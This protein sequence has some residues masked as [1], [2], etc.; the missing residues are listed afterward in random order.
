MECQLNNLNPI[1]FPNEVNVDTELFLPVSSHATSIECMSGYFTSGVL[2]ELAQSFKSFLSSNIG[3]IKFI[4]SPNLSPADVK[5][6]IEAEESRDDVLDKLFPNYH[7]EIESLKCKT[8]EVFFYLILTKRIE[9]KIAV[10]NEGVFHTKA[11]IFNTSEG[12]VTIHGSG[13]ATSNGLST[14]FE[15]LTLSRSW[16]NDDSRQVCG[17]LKNRFDKIWANNYIGIHTYPLN[18]KTLESVKRYIELKKTFNTNEDLIKDLQKKYNEYI[19]QVRLE[20]IQTRA[21]KIPSYLQYTEGVYAHQGK[22]VD[23]WFKNIFKGILAIATGGG[24]TL[25][26]LVAASKLNEIHKNLFVVIAVPT[27][28]LLNQWAEDVT[29]FGVIPIISSNHKKRELTSKINDAIR[30]IK[31]GISTCE[32]LIITHDA[33]KSDLMTLFDEAQDGVHFMLIGDEVHNLGSTGFIERAPNFFTFKLGLSA[34]YERQ[35]DADGT[36]FLIEYFGDVIFEYGLRDAIGYCLVPYDYYLHK[37]YLTAEEEDNFKEV[38]EKIRKLSYAA[39]FPDGSQEKSSWSN[40]CLKRRRII[41]TAENKISVFKDVFTEINNTKK[42]EKTLIFCTDK[43]NTQISEINNYLN[44]IS[45][46]WHQITSRETS[47]SARL[48]SIVSEFKNNELQVL[49]AMRVL[50]EGFNIPQTE[51]AYLLSSNTVRRQWI[52]RL[53]RILRLSPETGKRKAALHDFLVLPLF[54]LN[55]IDNDL[56]SLIRSECNRALFFSELSSNFISK[57]GSYD[58]IK[59]LITSLE[60]SDEYCH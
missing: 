25:T 14:N 46:N 51:T 21:L 50:D 60:K 35:F 12:T 6:L 33:L 38:T 16:K 36:K 23:A 55:N 9:L 39:N 11:W 54:D 13:N 40:L 41:E 48:L 15:Q 43:D 42:I 22:A 17:D 47:N 28:T 52:Q 27:I 30:N 29:K 44:S 1:Y 3:S 49:T 32:V 37:V 19:D 56:K 59:E 34:T 24:K 10:L 7:I 31:C 57:D 2:A 58:F 8:L 53:G 18:E 4:I 5:V 20:N 45:L 26:A